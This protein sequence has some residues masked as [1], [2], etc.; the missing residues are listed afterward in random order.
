MRKRVKNSAQFLSFSTWGLFLGMCL[1][2][3]AKLP[4]CPDF[5]SGQ[6]SHCFWQRATFFL[7]LEE[8]QGVAAVGVWRSAGFQPAV[9]PIS[10]RQTVKVQSRMN[11]RAPSRLETR[12]TAGWE[13]CATAALPG[14]DSGVR[15]PCVDALTRF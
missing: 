13:T 2:R 7:T 5:S 4:L 12:D 9:S 1:P 3:R 8:N 15:R 10:Y 6:A 11:V 14:S